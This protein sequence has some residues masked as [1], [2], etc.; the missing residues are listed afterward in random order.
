MTMM[1]R[2]RAL[3]LMGSGTALAIPAGLAEAATP[4]EVRFDHGVA[5]GD[6]ASDGAILWTRATPAED[7]AAGD[8]A[9]TWHVAPIG[10]GD[11]V[12]LRTGRVTARA[13]RDFTAKV[14]V[15]GLRPGR[16]YRYWFETAAGG[17]SAEGRFRTLPR[18]AIDDVV[19]A[20]VSCQLYPG[21]LFNAYDAIARSERLDAVLHLGDYIYEYGADG[22]GT[23]I[24][25][26]LGRLPEPAHEIVSLADYRQRHAQV[27]RDPD[28]QAAHARAAFIC[29]WDDHEVANDDWI[30]GAENHQPAVE[31]D[32][33][34]RKAAAMQAYFEWMPI[35]DP[36]PGEPWEAIYRSF[37]FGDL[38]TIVMLE[39]RL[40]ARSR[41]VQ[42][43]GEGPEP[44]EYAA[45]MAERARPDRTL[46]GPGQLAWVERTL[47][48][49]V[50]AGRPWQVIGNQVVMARIDGPDLEKQMG[51]ARFATMTERMEE[52]TRTQLDRALASFRAGLPLNFDSWDGYPA[53]R[54][55]LYAAF[56]RAGSHPVVVSGDSH[57]AWANDLYDAKGHLVA[58]EFGS[59]AITSPS[60]GDLMPGIGREIAAANPR[61][62]RF[63]D[64]DAKGYLHLTLTRD[65]ATARFMT[66][67]TV[68]AK[69]YR[70]GCAAIW[71]TE[72]GGRA[73]IAPVTA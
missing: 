68:L 70:E 60:W 63:C 39:S 27:K 31:G 72:A 13:A 30:G 38:A 3:T 57:A 9:L 43:K 36:R 2:R 7:G 22:Y 17:R 66:V 44:S 1:N 12:G 8:I 45:M 64:Q 14:E 69:P 54:E 50:R 15:T 67:S 33:G 47:G 32:W 18:G 16:D 23:Q 25:H 10:G 58:A 41:Q 61:V 21:G 28:M 53:E 19:L 46:L 26:K 42:A 5:S 29:V 11:A 56:T 59:T 48:A 52:G 49:S 35:R 40:L 20:V 34:K 51:P 55:R 65:T 6:P 37:D 4:A 71:R 73:P 24:G 62:V